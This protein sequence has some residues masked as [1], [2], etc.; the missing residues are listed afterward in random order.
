[1]TTDP[2]VRLSQE[3]VRSSAVRKRVR[4][5]EFDPSRAPLSNETFLSMVHHEDRGEV[6]QA[7]LRSLSGSSGPWSIEHRIQ[8]A[9]GKI[10]FVEERWQVSYNDEGVP[11]RASGTCQDI[12]DR[13]K[14]GNALRQSQKH[15]RDIIDGL[16][17]SMFVAVLT[18]RGILVDINRPPLEAAGL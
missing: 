7:L 6:E 11:I 4:I 16:G 18:P 9:D 5:F 8:L 10:K 13:V 17:P 15:L 1:M 14:A 3:S 12:T 2:P